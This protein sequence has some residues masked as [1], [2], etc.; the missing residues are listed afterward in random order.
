MDREELIRILQQH[1]GIAKVTEEPLPADPNEADSIVI[2]FDDG[3]VAH[4]NPGLTSPLVPDET[5]DDLIQRII[6]TVDTMK[7]NMTDFDPASLTNIVPLV[8]A[9]DYF[10]DHGEG[11]ADA[12]GW[13]TDYIGFG[14]AIDEPKILRIINDSQLPEG[15]DEFDILQLQSQAIENLHT[16]SEYLTV[17]EVGLGSNVVAV[18][19]PA[20]NESAWFADAAGMENALVEL[21]NQTHT[22]WLVI[23]ARRNQ[24]FFVNSDAT[25]EEWRGLLDLLEPALDA[26]D[27][28]HPLPHLI[29]D[30]QWEERLPPTDTDWGRRFRKLQLTAQSRIYN[31]LARTL[32]AHMAGRNQEQQGQPSEAGF[33]I[34]D[35]TVYSI[36]DELYS[37]AEITETAQRTSVPITDMI[38]IA[39]GDSMLYVMFTD[40]CRECPHLVEPQDD[41]HPPR[42]IITR[43]MPRDYER[44]REFTLA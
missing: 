28:L 36:N 37:V 25:P 26:H 5:K 24:L 22:T 18:S 1:P 38:F 13:L 20:D 43:P 21:Y 23:P 41:Q 34:A 4:M 27:C 10:A 33:E 14:L 39:D 12:Y 42:A 8:R 3:T 35:F 11:S 29:V 6:H 44:L 30:G 32:A 9:A 40:L 16:M 2:H 31:V 19:R 7:V 15:H 17:S